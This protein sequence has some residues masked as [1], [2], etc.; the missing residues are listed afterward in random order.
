MKEDISYFYIFTAIKKRD[1]SQTRL[2][3]IFCDN[4]KV[5]KQSAKL[6]H[7][8]I[9]RPRPSVTKLLGGE[10]RGKKVT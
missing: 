10:L 6:S 8:V 9:S 5:V 1:V 4:D 3:T 7:D 2:L